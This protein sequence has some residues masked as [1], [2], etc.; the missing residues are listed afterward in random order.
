MPKREIENGCGG[1][2]GPSQLG[3]IQCEGSFGIGMEREAR[4]FPDNDKDSCVEF[5]CF[6]HH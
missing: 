1:N 2:G 3:V 6:L 5:F 4:M